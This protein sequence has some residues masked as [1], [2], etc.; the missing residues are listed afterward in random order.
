MSE[1]TQ[2]WRVAYNQNPDGRYKSVLVSGESIDAAM[3]IA[4]VRTNRDVLEILSV[5]KQEEEIL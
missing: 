1:S 4:K 2:V 5:S 3:A